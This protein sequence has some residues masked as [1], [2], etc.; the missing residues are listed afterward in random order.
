MTATK[1]R[2]WVRRSTD[3]WR[4]L[5]GQFECSGQTQE[6]FCAAHDLALS[7]F[8]RWREKLRGAAMDEPVA[9]REAMFVEL[10]SEQLEQRWDMELDLGAGV[11]LRLRRQRC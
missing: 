7:T 11:V 2:R 9:S 4:E 8:S 3:E 6:Q 10:A 5:L 1:R